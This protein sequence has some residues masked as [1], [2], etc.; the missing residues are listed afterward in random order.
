M[1]NSPLSPIL[2]VPIAVF[3]RAAVSSSEY[4]SSYQLD[5]KQSTNLKPIKDGQKN[6]ARN[7]F[8]SLYSLCCKP[9]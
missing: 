4:V 9:T 6:A 8:V 5:V 1:M 3:S 7:V 2:I